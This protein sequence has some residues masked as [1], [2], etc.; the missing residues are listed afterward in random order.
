MSRQVVSH[1]GGARKVAEPIQVANPVAAQPVIAP[2]RIEVRKAFNDVCM[3]C[4]AWAALSPEMRD[5]YLR[6][7]ER[8]CFEATIQSCILDGIDRLF[9]EKKFVQRYST[10]C[11][12]IMANLDVN[13]AVGSTYLIDKVIS[14]EIDP[15]KIAELTSNDLCPD[16][17]KT[18][19]EEIEIRMRQKSQNKVSRAHTCKKC[20]GQETIPIEYQGRCADEG[21]NYSIKCIHCEFV[22]RR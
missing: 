22:W 19:R 21:S 9:T 18:E 6:R 5:M 16:A 20:G 4:P 15:Y 17:S 8:S 11:S 14:G 13:G 7:I 12:R 3:Q 2:Q 1:A 10:N